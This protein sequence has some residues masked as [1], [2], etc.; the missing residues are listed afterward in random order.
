MFGDI[1]K[2]MNL[3]NNI[4]TSKLKWFHGLIGELRKK[5]LE[6]NGK[7]L[8]DEAKE[9]YEDPLIN[10]LMPLIEISLEQ[11]KLHNI[12]SLNIISKAYVEGK[13]TGETIEEL[14]ANAKK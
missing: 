14:L 4:D 3:L 5:Q 11:L 1:T 13:T 6:K 9:L 2:M 7:K 8:T 10:S 12:K